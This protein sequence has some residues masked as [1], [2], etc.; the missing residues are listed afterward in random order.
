M[1]NNAIKTGLI[2]LLLVVLTVMLIEIPKQYYSKEDKELLDDIRVTEYALRAADD[3]LEIKQKIDVLTRDDCLVVKESDKS[4]TEEEKQKRMS[5]LI[6][7]ISKMLDEKQSAVLNEVMMNIYDNI[8]WEGVNIVCTIDDKIYSFDLGMAG[9]VDSVGNNIGVIYDIE[10]GKII[11]L[12]AYI[13]STDSS[14]SAIDLS[15]NKEEYIETLKEYFDMN[16]S[17]DSSEAVADENAICASPFS[18]NEALSTTLTTIYDIL[19]NN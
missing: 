14:Y 3:S 10:T 8:R 2:M 6:D 17:S 7:E 16:I 13:A 4:I 15:K 19:Y 9:Y 18:K 1:K 5:M 11:H 12:K